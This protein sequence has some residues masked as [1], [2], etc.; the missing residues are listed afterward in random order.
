MLA[1]VAAVEVLQTARL[2]LA[3]RAVA[4]TVALEATMGQARRPT[5]AVAAG[6]QGI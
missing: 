1:A 5:R 3:V 2:V 4:R 6:A